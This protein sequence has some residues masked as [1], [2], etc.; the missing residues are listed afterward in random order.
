VRWRH[1]YGSTIKA[2]LRGVTLFVRTVMHRSHWEMEYVKTHTCTCACILLAAWRWSIQRVKLTSGPVST[3]MGDRLR[4][5]KLS[6][7]VTNNLPFVY[8]RVGVQ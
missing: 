1:R 2:I 5:R 8:K 3:W 4:T 7:Y 6:M